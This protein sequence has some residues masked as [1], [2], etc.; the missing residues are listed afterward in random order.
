MSNRYPIDGAPLF[1]PLPEDL[2]NQNV[3]LHILEPLKH[4]KLEVPLKKISPSDY[5]DKLSQINTA[6]KIIGNWFSFPYLLKGF[7]TTGYYSYRFGCGIGKGY[8]SRSY[9]E[10]LDK[11]KV[12]LENS[13]TLRT[14]FNSNL[15]YQL[16]LKNNTS[17]FYHSCLV[18]VV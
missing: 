16:L 7:V 6:R 13:D 11:Y 17:R 8:L 10:E 12:H 3:D 15:C 2:Q 14:I 9:L 18:Y 4:T 1:L 5:L